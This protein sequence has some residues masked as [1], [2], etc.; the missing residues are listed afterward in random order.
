M[1]APLDSLPSSNADAFGMEVRGDRRRRGAVTGG[2][3]QR[4]ALE[5]NELHEKIEK[6]I[7]AM[8]EGRKGL[9]NKVVPLKTPRPP[10]GRNPNLPNDPEQC[11]NDKT[12][13]LPQRSLK[14]KLGLAWVTGAQQAW[15]DEV[16]AHDSDIIRR[17]FADED[18]LKKIESDKRAA[19]KVV[20]EQTFDSEENVNEGRGRAQLD[21]TLLPSNSTTDH[22]VA[23]LIKA[24]SLLVAA[25]ADTHGLSHGGGWYIAGGEADANNYLENHKR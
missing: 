25:M 22:F 24:S 19:A 13:L 11:D 20:W 12:S 18:A 1:A 2:N 14:S 10:K 9:Q 16:D 8:A 5:V 21:Q 15:I 3:A 7:T 4:V 23:G 17:E 6:S